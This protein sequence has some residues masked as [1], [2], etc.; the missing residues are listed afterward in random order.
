VGKHKGR[1]VV[2]IRERIE[3]SNRP[4]RQKVLDQLGAE[5]RK[6]YESALTISWVPDTH[7][8][9]I[10]SAGARLLHPGSL[11]GIREIGREQATADLGGLYSVL[12]AITTVSFALSRTAQFWRTFNDQGTPM[13]THEPG[14]NE[15][16]LLVEDYPN[17]PDAL[18]EYNCGYIIGVLGRAGAKDIRVA[19]G[20]QHGTNP[21]WSATWK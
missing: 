2:F 13:L 5:E 12:L 17:F 16:V 4:D 1:T 10:I 7:V 3:Q 8:A 20:Y 21:R 14:T 19:F 15:A 18:G 9:A 11:S 6:T